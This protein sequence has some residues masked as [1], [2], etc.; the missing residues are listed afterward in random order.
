MTVV[1]PKSISGIN[2]IT[3]ASGSDNLLTIHTSDAN[4]TERLRIDSTGATKIVTG[5]VTTLTATTGIVT[6][7]TANTVTS[8]G[9]VSGT[10]GTFSAA[11]SGTT[12]TFTGDVD[13]AD[14][15]VHTGDTNTAIR[16][17]AADTITAETG[18]T[19]RFRITSDGKIGINQTPTREL[20]LHSPDN[21]N[22]L[23]H[24]TNDDT[25]ETSSDGIL[26][27]LDGNENMNI[28]HQETGKDINLYM[29]GSQRL[30]VDS[31]GR[32]II[33]AQITVDT[34]GYYD[35][36]TLNNSSTASGEA[37]GAGLSIVSGSSSYGGVI[38]S[39]S[40][41]HGR[42][43]VK[44]DQTNDRLL[45]GTQ[46]IDR[47]MIEDSGNNGDVHIKTGNIVFDTSGRGIDFS[48]TGD[49]SGMTSELLDDYEEGTF[50]LSASGGGSSFTSTVSRYIKIGIVVH[51][52]LQLD[53]FS[54]GSSSQDL[55]LNG[56]PFTSSSSN[57]SAAVIHTNIP[58]ISNGLIFQIAG[59]TSSAN[60][61]SQFA[62]DGIKQNNFDGYGF[63]LNA[64]YV[65]G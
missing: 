41:S 65:A 14:K 49:A 43:Y 17:P 44:Y 63:S 22:A 26:L 62:S 60:I 39:R 54:G 47:V 40:N 32:V 6:T 1:N 10:T 18:G 57:N 23:I 7:L 30:K 37:G 51:I 24:F 56:L 52:F 55:V 16:F 21:N 61:R 29:G 45:L 13:I 31:N 4:N 48:A 5:I 27:G 25:G 20:S 19:E 33:G 38:F 34:G 3:M 12:G 2:S 35:D 64:T 8:L 28:N 59:N 50:T 53:S 42:G 36:I 9:A 46:T 11:V 58:L 15:I